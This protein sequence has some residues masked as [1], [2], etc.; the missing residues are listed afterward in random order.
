MTATPA[1]RQAP[2]PPATIAVVV[3]TYRR[4]HDLRRCLDALET[5]ERRPDQVIVAVRDTD[6]GT[7]EALRTSV[8]AGLRVDHV[9]VRRPGV[10]AALIGGLDAVRS[11]IVAITDDDAIPAPDWLARLERHFRRDPTVGAVG[12]RDRIHTGDG[13]LPGAR[14]DV[15]R[16]RWYGRITGNHHVGTGR[17]RAVDVL[18]GVNMSFRTRA[19]DGVRPD[20]RL[21]GAGA[22]VHFELGLCLALRRRGWSVLYDPALVVD[23]HPAVR[24]SGDARD[25][26]TLDALRDAAHNE[27]YLLMR[28][29]PAWRKP[30]AVVY[31]LLIGSRETP[32]LAV[33][34]E[35]LIRRARAGTVLAHF[36]AAEHGR[37]IA[38]RTAL[39]P[40]AGPARRRCLTGR[41]DQR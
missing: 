23:H 30:L 6:D 22:Q 33:L 41:C 34:I 26:P 4:P 1:I 16:V 8:S 9:T 19:L 25:A 5:Q 31:G 38:I 27:L 32:G 13:V 10:V 18:K 37:L 20:E 2:P 28:W 29:L 12:G 35:R 15:G 3:P 7:R 17:A 14:S 21:R 24:V 36:H 39:R 11:D 40:P